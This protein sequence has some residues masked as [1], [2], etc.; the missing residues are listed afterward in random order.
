MK[1]SRRRPLLSVEMLANL[2]LLA[3]AFHL[4][5]RRFATYLFPR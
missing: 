5:E 2:F 4:Y 1:C 3:G